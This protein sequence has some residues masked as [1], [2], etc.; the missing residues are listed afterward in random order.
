M[1][2]DVALAPTTADD[3]TGLAPEVRAEL[4]A[5]AQG[6]RETI[7]AAAKM[8]RCEAVYSE[9]MSHVVEED[10]VPAFNILVKTMRHGGHPAAKF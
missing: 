5:L 1:D 3:N 8:L 10:F 4:L 2:E 9:D 6:A 7:G